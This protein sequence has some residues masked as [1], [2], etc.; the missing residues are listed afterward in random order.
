MG[1]DD[2]GRVHSGG[3]PTTTVLRIVLAT[4]VVRSQSRK[5]KV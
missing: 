5:Y 4:K 1:E 2:D 3:S